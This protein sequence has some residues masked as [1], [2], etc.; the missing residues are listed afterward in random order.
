MIAGQ[1]TL[2]KPGSSSTRMASTPGLP[3]FAFTCW[4]AARMLPRSH[5]FSIRCSP[6]M[7]RSVGGLI[8]GESTLAPGPLG[9]TAA[10]QLKAS[11]IGWLS[12]HIALKIPRLL[13]S[14]HRSGLQCPR[15]LLC[16][17][18]TPAMRSRSLLAA[19]SLRSGCWDTPQ[20]SRGKLLRFRCTTA[21]FTSLAL[22]GYGL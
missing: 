21:G 10:S 7:R 4:S 22:D 13:A 11:R 14:P 2:R 16:P 18:L 12:F 17:L 6:N 19:Q 9:F 1:C 15:H 8:G 5:I 3:L 20:V